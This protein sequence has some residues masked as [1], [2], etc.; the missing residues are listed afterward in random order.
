MSAKAV[1]DRGQ[2]NLLSPVAPFR[3]FS[4]RSANG[5]RVERLPPAHL[6]RVSP[7]AFAAAIL[8]GEPVK[9]ALE[10]ALENMTVVDAI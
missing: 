2:L 9:T 5:N 6:L 4:V 10:D 8:R 1:D 3:R 7:D